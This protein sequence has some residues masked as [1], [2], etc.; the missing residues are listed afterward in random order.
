[1]DR[2]ERVFGIPE[3]DRDLGTALP[4]GWVTLLVTTTGS[5]S[6][7]FA[8]QFANAGVGSTPVFYYTTY[9]RTVEVER[10]FRDM[11]WDPGAIKILNLSEEYY[12]RVLS[13]RLEV[14]RVR[15][16]GIR[17]SD[18]KLDPNLTVDHHAFNLSSRIL[19]DLASID[20][21]FR[22]TLDSLDFLLEILEPPEVIDVARQ[23]CYR[24]QMLGG[25][26]LLLIHSNTHTQRT[27][28]LLED[29]VDMVVE[30]RTQPRGR[31]IHHAL[32]VLKLRNHPDRL[33][34]VPLSLGDHGFTALTENG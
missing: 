14:S 2:Q 18:L 4:S 30:L 6:Q 10:I 12:D 32:S 17:L 7:L 13:Q 16:R 28:G 26:V 8:K 24:A 27:V 34:E 31:T 20:A 19:G 15:E 21:P 5:G 25:Q 29:M 3:I 33:R 9:E 22:L 11:G 1:M 23:I